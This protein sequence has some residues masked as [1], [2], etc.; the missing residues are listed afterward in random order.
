ME[1]VHR[2]ILIALL[3]RPILYVVGLRW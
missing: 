3:Y 1:S 2:R